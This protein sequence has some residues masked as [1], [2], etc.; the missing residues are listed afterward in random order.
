M[1]AVKKI[2]LQA[3]KGGKDL[4]CYRSLFALTQAFSACLLVPA[5]EGFEYM[6][7]FW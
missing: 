7:R 4:I 1:V 2:V 6:L 5:Q 3:L